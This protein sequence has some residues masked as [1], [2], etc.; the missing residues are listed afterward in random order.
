MVCV[1]YFLCIEICI[2]VFGYS[3]LNILMDMKLPSVLLLA[4]NYI[5]QLFDWVM[6]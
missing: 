1:Q 2:F 6:I 5:N 3:A 4:F